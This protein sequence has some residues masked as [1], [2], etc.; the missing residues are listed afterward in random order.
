[1]LAA[2]FFISFSYVKKKIVFDT[3]LKKHIYLSS[4]TYRSEEELRLDIPEAD[5]YCTGSDQVW[6]SHWNEGI[7]APFY[8][9]FIPDEAYRF[10]YAAS[11]GNSRLEPDEAA[12]V[13]PMLEKYRHISV[14][15]DDGV[16][17]IGNL[18]LYAE[19]MIDPTLLFTGQEWESYV[20]DRFAKRKYVVTYNLHHDKKIDLFAQR[21][22]ETYGLELLNIS[23]NLHDI[24][25]NGKL[26]WC[27]SVE[28]YL[29]LI[30]DAQYIVTDSFHASVFSI[31]FHIKFIV[32]FPEQAS[33]RIRS[34][35]SLL[36]MEA[37]GSDDIPPVEM[38]AQDI[39]FELGEQIL[40]EERAR[41]N[42]FFSSVLGE[43]KVE[44]RKID[45]IR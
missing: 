15:E 30:K 14:R 4:K 5:I 29:G 8:L 31:L 37:R 42:E 19:Q 13:R 9:S 45:N 27:P 40:C 44:K 22:A 32:I 11:I 16:N 36:H 26:V 10:S 2:R 34:L 35:L 28:E 3:F 38:V 24:I 7:D 41:S 21:V 6:N 20:S 18:G 17:V 33:S 1:L 23:Y 12:E 25:R 39:D 43:F